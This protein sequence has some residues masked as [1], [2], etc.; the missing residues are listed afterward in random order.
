MWTPKRIGPAL[1]GWY[2][3]DLGI[4]LNGSTVSAWADQSGNGNHVTQGT[5]T[6]QPTYVASSSYFGRPALS[7]DGGDRMVCATLSAAVK[8]ITYFAVV[9]GVTSSNNG[10][11][12][13]TNGGTVNTGTAF[14]SA[15]STLTARR[16]STGGAT[17]AITYAAKNVLIATI[18]AT[19]ATTYVNS[20]TFGGTPEGAKAYTGYSHL[21]IGDIAS[22]LVYP[23]NGEI[24]E[25]CILNRVATVAE[26]AS[27]VQ[28]AS[29]RYGIT[30]T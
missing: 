25:V 30:V 6:A 9:R 29:T 3:A 8:E 24:E 1:M 20:K 17:Q 27:L 7:F 22:S 19:A 16:V 21:T 18:D 4:T 12:A 14:F 11:A 13:I 28:Y 26:I 2:R 5:G 15:A 23:W 10:I